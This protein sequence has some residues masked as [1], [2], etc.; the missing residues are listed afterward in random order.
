MKYF[1]G[2]RLTIPKSNK[3]D[4][5]SVLREALVQAKE[6]GRIT[7]GVYNCA[8]VLEMNPTG[9]M[10]CIL[11]ENMS[12]DVTLHIHF[13]L[14][15]AYCWE[16]DIKLIKVDSCEKL[17][18]CLSD[19]TRPPPPVNDNDVT[20][21]GRNYTWAPMDY[22]CV[23][24]EYPEDDV[25]NLDEDVLVYCKMTADTLPQPVVELTG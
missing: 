10:Y 20:S 25:S 13:T 24:V 15:E 17:A 16:N 2:Q 6:E 21:P 12:H 22:A 19:M 1:T 3:M 11:P 8:Q 5:G 23:L 7:C 4:I 9:V 14:I 18:S